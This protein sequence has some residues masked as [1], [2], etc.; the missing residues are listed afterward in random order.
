MVALSNKKIRRVGAVAAAV[1][2]AASGTV[3][4]PAAQ[5][6]QTD[7]RLPW[8]RLRDDRVKQWSGLSCQEIRGHAL[9]K[10]T[11][12]AQCYLSQ[13]TREKAKANAM[14]DDALIL[15]RIDWTGVEPERRRGTEKVIRESIAEAFIARAEQCHVFLGQE[16][17][18]TSFDIEH[19]D[20]CGGHS[21]LRQ[22]RPTVRNNGP[23]AAL[24]G[25]VGAFSS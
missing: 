22:P 13:T 19:P 24:F 5:A 15:D 25:S 7:S 8:Q 10:D 18:K 11:Q 1:M 9:A 3:V 2:L 16:P 17:L 21:Q 4:A 23:F 6:Q 12:N 14:G 20:T